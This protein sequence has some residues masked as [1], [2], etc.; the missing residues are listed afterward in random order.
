MAATRQYPPRLHIPPSIS[1]VQQP[2]GY[3]G[4]PMFS[5]ALPSGMP[6]FPMNP[7]AALQTPLQT[8]FFPPHG[9]QGRP[10]HMGHGNRP[11]LAQLAFA[12]MPMP[13][14]GPMT[15]LG[16]NQF[17]PPMLL[18]G[19][20]FTP[21]LTTRNRRAPSISIGGPPKAALGGPGRNHSP[22]PV[23]LATAAAASGSA[24]TAPKTK[25][26]IVK[27]PKETLKDEEN[28]DS[29]AR[30]SWART[31]MHPSYLPVEPD[32]Q[33]P[34][35]ISA[36]AYPSDTWRYELPDSVD[37]FLPGKSAW[38]AVK[39]KVIEEKLEKLGVERGSG[40]N[41]PHIHAPHARA[42]SIS[43]PADPA[44]LFFKLNKLQQSQNAS[45]TNSIPTSPQPGT[46]LPTSPNPQVPPRFQNR[47]GHSMSLAQPSTAQAASVFYSPASGFNPFGPTATLGSD[48]ISP[49]PLSAG[50]ARNNMVAPQ[51]RV[52]VTI[53]SLAPPPSMSRPESRPDFIRGFGLDIPEESEEDLEAELA[54]T[55]DG[56]NA[57][58]SVLAENEGEV[59]LD[60]GLDEYDQAT[61]QDVTAGPSSRVHSR[62]VS[63]L[64]AALSLRSVGGVPR[65]PNAD[66]PLVDELDRD[67]VQ[68]WTG[69]EDLRTGAEKSDDEESLGEF[70][71]PSDEE[72]ARMQRVQR[73]NMRRAKGDTETPRRLP[74][75][76][77]PPPY[78][79]IPPEM[80]RDDDIVSNPSDE[81]R[82]PEG[83]AHLGI[84]P[85]EYFRP[86][87]SDSGGGSRP[88]PPLPHSRQT[89]AQ[90]SHHDPALAHSRHP[91]EQFAYQQS[92]VPRREAP[93]LNPLAKPFVFGAS[94][95]ST[96]MPAALEPAPAPTAAQPSEPVHSRVPSFGKR[97]NVAAP[98]FKPT[99]SFAPPPA[100]A[101]FTFSVSDAARPLPIPPA[102]PVPV[103]AQ[104]GREKRARLSN[105]DD[106]ELESD[107][108]ADFDDVAVEEEDETGRY[109][110]KAF[111]FPPVSESPQVVRRS[112]PTTPPGSSKYESLGAG[113]KPF[114]FGGFSTFPS[115]PT[116]AGSSPAGQEAALPADITT[117]AQV[118][119]PEQM[120]RELPIPPQYKPKR[121]PIPLDFKHPVS[122]NTVP[123]GLFKALV[124]GNGEERTRR[125]VRSRLS[126]REIFDHLPRS[127]LDD[128]NVPS[129]S[130]KISGSRLG[131]DPFRRDSI[132]SS[133]GSIVMRPRRSSLPA[134]HSAA[135]SSM[136]G[137]SIPPIANL[138]KRGDLA[139]FE[140][141]LESFLDMK[142]EELRQDIY[143]IRQPDNASINP[144]TEAMINEVV[145]LF[146]AQLQESAMRDL[147]N[148][149]ADA[150]GEMDFELIRDVIERGQ[151]EA[152]AVMRQELAELR[153]RVEMQTLGS[154][155]GLGPAIEEYS[156][157]TINAIVN[158]VSQLA[159]RI[160]SLASASGTVP[161]GL[162]PS[163]D[164]ELL[165]RDIVTVLSPQLASLRSEP[166]DYE[167]LTTQLTQAV[168][169]HIAQLI[170]LASDKRETAGLIV[171]KLLPLLPNLQSPPA[172][173]EEAIVSRLTTEM[174]RVV[175]P[176]DAH[177]IK[178]QVSDLVVERLDS[179]L[180][181][182][183]KTF[184]VET[185]TAKVEESLSSLLQPVK[186]VAVSA[187]VLK[188]SQQGLSAQSE[189]LISIQEDIKA[190]LSALPTQVLAAT[191][192][193][194]AVQADL[195]T[196][197]K[198]FDEV[199]K[200]TPGTPYLA[201]SINELVSGQKTIVG[202]NNE[203]TTFRQDVMSSLEALPEMLTAS[204][205]VLQDAYSDL[206][207][208]AGS[209]QDQDEL[210]RLTTTNADL[211]VQ[212]AKARGAHGQVRVEKDHFNERLVAVE[213]ERN[214]LRAEVEG[215]QTTAAAKTTEVLA[216]ESKTS[217]LEEALSQALAR[218]KASDVASQTHQER[219]AD[220]ERTSREIR[221]DKE[222]LKAKVDSLDSQVRMASHDKESAE[223]SLDILQ[224]EHERVL[225]QQV[226]LDDLRRTTGQLE[227][228]IA[229]LQSSDN[230]ELRELR[231]I[232]DRS[233]TMEGEYAALQ[234]RV[235][236]Q[237]TKVANSERA[238][239]A[240]KQTLT[241]TQQRAAEWEKRAKD[242]E[243]D[244]ELTR[245]KLDQ[246][247]QK[248]AQ[249][250]ADY[251]L[252]KLQL[253]EKDADSRLSKD[254]ENE[255]REQ[256][257]SLEVQVARLQGELE[258]AASAPAPLTV[259][260][261]QNGTARPVSRASTVYGP[262]RSGT[263][264]AVNGRG[265]S[266]AGVVSPQTGVWESIHAPRPYRNGI[267]VT[268]KGRQSQY[269]RPQIPSPTPSTVSLAPT[270]GEDGWWS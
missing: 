251:S 81:G 261:V 141:R 22:L 257:S 249:L 117:T 162:P 150:R 131:A 196:R 125:A 41:V 230:E 97:L 20:P 179:R 262:S 210:R 108:G 222:M 88:L 44:L 151:A 254:R 123:A 270:L 242:R 114:T 215:L 105:A 238:A 186:D 90:Y 29:T 107:A 126:S 258:K 184:N 119:S 203:I 66:Q 161:I 243:A 14:G 189:K 191:E 39:Q 48:S 98:E 110:F 182:R 37:V 176:L 127:S 38:N 128:T 57:D 21:P 3:E 86:P 240:A 160:D 18:N 54:A 60:A 77:R 130:R 76:P 9:L 216:L 206:I 51:A 183:D 135:G 40:S 47:H 106:V 174:R 13:S 92:A 168:K 269:Y 237:E 61:Q 115:V 102:E 244:L 55:E 259:Q 96:F 152:Q 221:A 234:K 118:G 146:R 236:E 187:D 155:H 109:S 145:L 80:L 73:R 171:E 208:R 140:R 94:A 263:P 214:Q 122:T 253:E 212:L 2:P 144:G 133:A 211:Q 195:E 129:I 252:A 34:E 229:L 227:Q 143:D 43:S 218:L 148:S 5:P 100:A 64:S 75:F 228:V 6:Q 35:T 28:T 87:T 239:T 201:S 255:L 71:N 33:P 224:K 173:D 91:S 49:R 225:S 19:G 247:E 202:L 99:F 185:L 26:V 68:E 199:L 132:A 139:E 78:M 205:K 65:S 232:R 180:A 58:E 63:R 166:I 67:A 120:V 56:A 95:A 164:R 177:E 101:E 219:I 113:T 62:H 194:Q 159:G 207:S 82:T 190:T 246:E 134:L 157:R 198:Q 45:T 266:R 248:S 74:N 250:D 30:P 83:H 226:E 103:R 79:S 10:P 256:V 23:P 165:V 121:A 169:P 188:N 93:N 245:T 153:Q 12:G 46:S 42:A 231:R 167:G 7:Q 27:L 142:M 217:E 11:S 16:Q 59:I 193:L 138:S 204:T 260:N 50:D 124:N 104:Q 241:T 116:D 53:S 154:H 197:G 31:P 136:S 89:S 84:D 175:A 192:R 268:P 149:R 8:S 223:R 17:A 220:L 112:A 163:L 213:A 36:E 1:N 15:P 181:V 32:I 265:A 147:E 52:P 158:T 172:L 111:K 25:K 24:A 267:P 235:K 170:D 233:K 69:S 137:V 264:L 156:A 85:S 178:E 209:R 200:T 72:R 4:P 70:S